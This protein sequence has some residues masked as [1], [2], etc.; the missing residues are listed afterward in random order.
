M[1]RILFRDV[2]IFDGSGGA[3]FPGQVLIEGNA[4]A[5]VSA[6]AAGAAAG[7]PPVPGDALVI[8]GHG[9]TLMPGLVE[10]H[11]HLSW[12]SSVGNVINAMH[13]PPEEHLL[14]TAYN[15]RVTLDHGYTSA[16]SAG[17]LGQRFEVALRDQINAGHLPGPRLRASS[18]ENAPAGVPG[19][20]AAQDG[21]HARG[22]EGLRAYVQKMAKLGVDTI[23]ILLSSD[24]GFAPGGAQVLLYSEEEVAA[25]GESAREAGVWLACHAQA[26]QSVKMAVRHGF[27]LI[28]HCTY[29]D[30]EAL[31]MLE[32]SKDRV[33]VAPAPG[34]LYARVHEAA[35]F[36]IDRAAAERMG[37]VSGLAL[38]QQIYPA[39]RRRGIRVLPG[40]DYGFPYN[41]IGRNARDLQ[42]FVDLFGFEPAEVLS[43]AT[44]LG[45]ELMDLPVGQ[46]RPGYLADLLLV[47]GDPLADLRILQDKNRLLAIMQNGAFHKAPAQ[48]LH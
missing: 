39:M 33:F 35:E 31:D 30:E 10:P 19:V 27:R 37:A 36:G 43:A 16:Y 28:N 8:D 13:L 45:G 26:A 9:A 46:I 4:I 42:L 25:I 2:R 1:R 6:L 32:A 38:M 7:Q 21:A 34:L 14:I 12:P 18:I 40:G 23:K 5:S 24:E 47:D 20:P 3:S 15:A 11:A 44:R 29:A 22:V 41:P 48:S 17:S